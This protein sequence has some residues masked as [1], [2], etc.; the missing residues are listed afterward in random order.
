MASVEQSRAALLFLQQICAF[1]ASNKC[2]SISPVHD[3]KNAISG[4]MTSRL[5]RGSCHYRFDIC[6]RGVQ[7]IDAICVKSDLG[8]FA[9]EGWCQIS[10]SQNDQH[11]LA[12]AKDLM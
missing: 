10:I 8:D 2:L 12:V 3:P 4:F 7:A 11:I 1:S 6:C 5:K 9:W